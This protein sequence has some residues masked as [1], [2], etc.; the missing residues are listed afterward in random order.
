MINEL[1]YVKRP[2][3]TLKNVGEVGVQG[4]GQR[5]DVLT[6]CKASFSGLERAGNFFE[7]NS[8]ASAA[9]VQ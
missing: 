7:A 9:P 4:L 2:R 5:N 6:T 1:T 8:A 3:F